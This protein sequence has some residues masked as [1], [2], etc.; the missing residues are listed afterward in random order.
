MVSSQ[1]YETSLI[2]INYLWHEFWNVLFYRKTEKNSE[3][4]Y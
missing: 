3:T 4:D 2:E 1:A